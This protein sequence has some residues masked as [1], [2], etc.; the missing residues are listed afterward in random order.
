[1]IEIQ[2]GI[3]LLAETRARIIGDALVLLLE[4]DVALGQHH[5]IGELQ[6][7]HAVGFQ[8]HHRLELLGRHALEIA[9][10]IVR[11]EGVFLAADAGDQ[12]REITGRI[13]R[14]AL[15]HQVL[16]EMRQARFARGLVGGADFVPDHVGDDRRA[17]IG[18]DNQ[19]QPV[20]QLEI[21][22]LDVGGICRGD[23][24]ENRRSAKQR[25]RYQT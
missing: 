13:F 4:D 17:V 7:G 25:L 11:G 10:V 3:D 6:A 14:R 1:M 16:K 5:L 18:N 22:D 23:A 21:G 19:F 9:G 12:F 8:F 15:E 2:R 24:R 20:R